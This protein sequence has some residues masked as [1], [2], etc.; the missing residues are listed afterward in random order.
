MADS[1]GVQEHDQ[2]DVN[3]Q[4]QDEAQQDEMSGGDQ[5]QN[6]DDTE[7]DSDADDEV[8]ITIG[9]EAPPHDEEEKAAP[10]WVKDL[11]KADREKAKR[12]REL[13]QQ[14]AAKNAPQAQPTLG[15][16]PS[17]EG[18][19]FDT[20][21][22]ETELTTW[23]ERKRAVDEQAAKQ[24]KE[25]EDAQKAWQTKL[26]GYNA[27]KVSLKVPDFEDAEAV[28]LE[29]MTTTQQS[30]IVSGADTPANVIYALGKNPAKAKELASIKDPVKFAFAVA[31]LETQL[32]VT[33]RKA[34]PAPEKVVRGSAAAVGVTNPKLDRLEAEADATGDRSKFIAYQKQLKTA[35]AA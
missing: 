35:K 33:P 21:R 10:A 6:Q 13:E 30:I 20:D 25:Q 9:E 28:V 24:Q 19:D 22:F 5:D 16:K 18:C 32:K 4:D 26:D 23:H 2:D 29:S 12:I 11:R 27:A 17:L 3:D 14:V 8:V 7:N 34:P 1:N 15:A 31:K